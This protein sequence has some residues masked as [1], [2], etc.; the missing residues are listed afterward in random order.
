MKIGKMILFKQRKVSRPEGVVEK[1]STWV[2][3]ESTV[4]GLWK[5]AED[6]ISTQVEE[7]IRKKVFG[8]WKVAEDILGTQVAESGQ[9]KYLSCVKLR[10]IK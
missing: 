2:A 1:I 7:S 6:I 5:V 4:F 3:E 8:L 9:K 10:K